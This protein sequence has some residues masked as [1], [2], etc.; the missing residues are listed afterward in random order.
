[1]VKIAKLDPL[2]DEVE[3]LLEN[4]KHQGYEGVIVVG[5]KGNECEVLRT[6]F[7]DSIAV[8]GALSR[9]EHYLNHVIDVDEGGDGE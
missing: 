3:T 1:M 4:C 8:L 5:L 2:G 7:N 6:R 9:V